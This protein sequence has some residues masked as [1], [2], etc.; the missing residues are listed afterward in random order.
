MS[1]GPSGSTSSIRPGKPRRDDDGR[2]AG[3]LGRAFPAVPA[4]VRRGR[5]DPRRADART[6]QHRHRDHRGTRRGRRTR[7]HE[8]RSRH[9]GW[10]RAR[11]TTT[12]PGVPDARSGLNPADPYGRYPSSPSACTGAGSVDCA[13]TVKSLSSRYSFPSVIRT[14]AP[15]VARKW[16]LERSPG[17]GSGTTALFVVSTIAKLPSCRV[18]SVPTH[19][20]ETYRPSTDTLRACHPS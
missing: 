1:V 2:G 11:R 18:G 8:R 12:V 13:V 9:R 6:G 5:G 15:P 14:S 4:A 3:R 20:T 10:V 17:T 7:A 19:P 16:T